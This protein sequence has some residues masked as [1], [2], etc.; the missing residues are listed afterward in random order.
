MTINSK[1]YKY[2]YSSLLKEFQFL[3]PHAIPV[4]PFYLLHFRFILQIFQKAIEKLLAMQAYG[5]TLLFYDIVF[6][7][8]LI[9]FAAHPISA[10]DVTLLVPVSC[11]FYH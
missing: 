6:S 8:V 7:D 2:C 5:L 4:S 10:L 3:P 1:G 11:Y 9:I